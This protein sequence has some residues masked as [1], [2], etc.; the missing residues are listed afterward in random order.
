MTNKCVKT[1]FF[2]RDGTINMKLP[3]GSYV[4]TWEE[5]EFLPDTYHALKAVKE[6]GYKIILVT[7]Q[8]GIARN[9]MTEKQL[10]H[11]HEQMQSIL[12]QYGCR[13][14]H[15]FY[16]PHDIQEK[17]GCR[18]P[19]PGLLAMAEQYY[20]IDKEHSFMVGDSA[21]DMEAGRRYGVRTIRIGTVDPSADFSIM[22]LTELP[23]LL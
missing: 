15:I 6:K 8:R 10:L 21:S 11:I 23:D 9:I 20:C 5:F 12:E 7:N 18:K 13:F 19:E 14:D 16:C 4:R 2:D 1:V 3:E 22:S 17:C